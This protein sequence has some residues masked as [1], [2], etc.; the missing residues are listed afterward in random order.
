MSE[1]PLILV[2]E[3][4]SIIALGLELAVIDRGGTVL[5]PFANVSEAIAALGGHAACAAILDGELE[6]GVVTSLALLLLDGGIPVIIHSGKAVPQEILVAYPLV[7]T[8]SKPCS[9]AIVINRLFEIVQN[10][11]PIQQITK[12]VGHIKDSQ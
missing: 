2:V 4:D 6:D 3:D 12:I 8:I 11:M 10:G 1:Q 9:P 7:V 5:G